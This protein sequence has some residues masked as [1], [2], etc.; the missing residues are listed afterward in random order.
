MNNMK[1]FF[2]GVKESFEN[3]KKQLED[4]IKIG[5]ASSEKSCPIK[6]STFCPRHN[7]S[8]SNYTSSTDPV[9]PGVDN[10]KWYT[11]V[12][13]ITFTGLADGINQAFD[14]LPLTDNEKMAALSSAGVICWYQGYFLDYFLDSFW[15]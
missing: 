11:I 2:K 15:P 4:E 10:L 14:A 9:I 13:L 5:L 7:A 12:P 8:N 6:D 3:K 1:N